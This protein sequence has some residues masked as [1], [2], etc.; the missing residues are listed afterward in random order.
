MIISYCTSTISTFLIFA[1]IVEPLI[2]D[3]LEELVQLAKG[4]VT[5]V[6][7]FLLLRDDQDMLFTPFLTSGWH[8]VQEAGKGLPRQRRISPIAKTTAQSLELVGCRQNRLAIDRTE[9]LSIEQNC[10][11]LKRLAINRTEGLLKEQKNY[12]FVRHIMTYLDIA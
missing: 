2:H 11:R 10:Y 5:I 3:F 12:F 6:E 9:Q 7:L 1:V 4:D 8:K